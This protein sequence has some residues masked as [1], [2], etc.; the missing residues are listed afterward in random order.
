MSSSAIGLIAGSLSA[1]VAP[2][3]IIGEARAWQFHA[4]HILGTSVDVVISALDPQ[5]AVLAAKTIRWEIGRLDAIYSDWHDQSELARLND[6]LAHSLPPDLARL[7]EI[8]ANWRHVTGGAYDE[9]L[10]A[11]SALWRQSTT[12]GEEPTPEQ[13]RSALDKAQSASFIRNDGPFQPPAGFRFGV[14]GLAK[15]VIIDQ[16]LDAARRAAPAARGIMIDIGGDIRCWGCAPGRGGWPVAVADPFDPS[17]NGRPLTMLELRDQAVATSGRGSRDLLLRGGARPHVIDPRSGAP[18]L[19]LAAATVVA[20]RAADAD[21][22]ATALMFMT[23]EVSI[24]FANRTPGVAAHLV[25]ASG[26]QTAS[27]LWDRLKSAAGSARD[28]VTGTPSRPALQRP[29]PAWPTGF[30]LDVSY[31]VPAIKNA[32]Y[33]QPYFAIWITDT[34]D[35]VIRTLLLLGRRPGYATDNYLW[36]RS[37]GVEAPTK[38][39]AVSRSTRAPGRYTASWDERDDRGKRCLKGDIGCTS[40]RC[41]SSADMHT[42]R[43]IST[44]AEPQSNDQVPLNES[45]GWSARATGVRD[46]GGNHSTPPKEP[47]QGSLR[48]LQAMPYLARLPIGVRLHR[49]HLP[50][51]HRATAQ[52]SRMVCR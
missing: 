10:G 6:G 5:T 4:D 27:E 33:R 48:L 41:V 16:A 19:H 42:A 30:K 9:R 35:N 46:D 26:A 1:I 36:W 47:P 11:I 28:R 51:G 29:G 2:Q 7:L 24:A 23:P 34:D 50:I 43:S 13:L 49:P 15:G 45:S 20:D 22:L 32:R 44:W 8:A 3:P 17:D 21:A 14:D 31:E 25:S 12:N 38:L 40:R 18:V 39:A 52:P 37:Y